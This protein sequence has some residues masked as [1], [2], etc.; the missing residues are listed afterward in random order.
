MKECEGSCL[1][2][3]FRS[4]NTSIIIFNNKFVVFIHRQEQLLKS[5]H[6]SF[7]FVKV[8]ENVYFMKAFCKNSE[9]RKT[10]K[11]APIHSANQDSPKNYV[12]IST[13]KLNIKSH[14]ETSEA[15]LNRF[16]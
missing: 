14:K 1:N 7:I 11:N 16:H 13:Y 6:S 9:A 5:P 4:S 15:H 10:F 12:N 3:A 8:K 2:Y